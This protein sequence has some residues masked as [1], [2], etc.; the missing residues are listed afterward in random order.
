MATLL[1]S[2]F[3]K[4]L[5]VQFLGTL[6]TFIDRYGSVPILTY[7]WGLP[8]FGEWLLM[9]IVPT[10]LSMFEAGF[11]SAA[12]NK[13]V[14]LMAKDKTQEAANLYAVTARIIGFISIFIIVAV[15]CALYF[16]SPKTWLNLQ[17][18]SLETIIVTLLITTL[19]VIL[20]FRTQ[21]LYALYRSHHQQVYWSSVIQTT[22]LGEFI[23][24]VVMAMLGGGVIGVAA[25]ITF[26][27]FCGAAFLQIQSKKK[28]P[29]CQLTPNDT[30]LKLSRPL[31]KSGFGFMMM[32]MSQALN[33]QGFVW[34]IGFVVSPAMAAT[35]NIYRVYSRVVFQAGDIIRRAL[36]PELTA[37]YVAKDTKLFSKLLLKSI[38]SVILIG[39]IGCLISYWAVDYIIP[40]WTLG[41][42]QS[43]R[44]IIG[45]LLIVAFFGAIRY[46][47]FTAATAINQHSMLVMIEVII[48]VIAISA[49][50]YTDYVSFMSV[51]LVLIMVEAII[52]I[53]V[54]AKTL[55]IVRQNANH[56]PKDQ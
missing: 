1:K 17:T 13:I 39:F 20:I 22:R 37:S 26:A 35:F 23:M 34:L 52:A 29:L 40:Y 31:L 50:Y 12:G 27:R 19:N 33:I 3:Q 7:Y 15:S 5:G 24:V 48:N 45:L 41:T 4:M 6:I 36:W 16:G 46:V 43:N 2:R 44:D 54:F 30:S 51:S 28:I 42:V 14:E 21:L 55:S 10:Y 11:P 53:L 32:P 38:L 49:L 8:L 18:L 47:T 56:I 25:G 9:R